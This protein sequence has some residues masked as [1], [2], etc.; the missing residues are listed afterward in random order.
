MFF[1]KTELIKRVVIL[2]IENNSI[3]L[4][5][6]KELINSIDNKKERAVLKT[7]LI[8]YFLL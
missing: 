7:L 1:D 8:D 4:D 3:P 6:L 5:Y 2:H